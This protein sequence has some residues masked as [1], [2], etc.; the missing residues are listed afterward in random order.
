[1]NSKFALPP[2]DFDSGGAQVDQV[3]ERQRLSL[4]GDASTLS[5]RL[6]SIA[7]RA[8]TLGTGDSQE[9][10]FVV[11]G[12]GTITCNGSEQ[13][14]TPLCGVSL[15]PRSSFSIATLDA[16]KRLEIVR[17]QIIPHTDQI[18]EGT[19][20]Q[21]RQIASTKSEEATGGRDFQV[22][23]D[24]A[25]GFGAG[26]LFIGN[27]PPG[28][29]APVHYH[30]YDE[31]ICILEGRGTVHIEGENIDVE[32]G[33][34]YRLP[35]RIL[36]QVDNTGSGSLREI[37]LFVPEGTPAAAYLPDGQGAFVGIPNDPEGP[38]HR[39]TMQ[40]LH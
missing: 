4:H 1:M 27:V 11:S 25:V 6:I 10:L 32:R 33:S 37:G 20:F 24:A 9:A 26:T 21:V 12:H 14:L 22:L 19:P 2:I 13:L 30:T 36:H 39:S 28:P 18:G 7:G 40:P 38:R 8:D 23:L 5:Q 3:V 16:T 35:A 29:P 31:V 17:V 15:P 34:C